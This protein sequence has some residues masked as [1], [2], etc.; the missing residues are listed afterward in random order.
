MF[1]YI[2]LGTNMAAGNQQ[3]H[4]SLSF[5]MIATVCLILDEVK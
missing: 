3:N 5:A 2:G 1:V 4:L